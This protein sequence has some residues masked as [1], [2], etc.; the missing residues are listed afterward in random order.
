MTTS[1]IIIADIRKRLKEQEMDITFYYYNY[2]T[3]EAGREGT[4]EEI[5]VKDVITLE[6]K[7][8]FE[9]I[10]KEAVHRNYEDGEGES[11]H[12]DNWIKPNIE[13]EC[14]YGKGDMFEPLTHLVRAGEDNRSEAETERFVVDDNASYISEDHKTEK[15]FSPRYTMDEDNSIIHRK[16]QYLAIMFYSL[17]SEL[18]LEALPM[19]DEFLTL[20][21][22][23]RVIAIN[24]DA[25]DNLVQGLGPKIELFTIPSTKLTPSKLEKYSLH[26]LPKLL[27]VNS[28]GVVNF[29]GKPSKFNF[30]SLE[31]YK[32]D[33]NMD[34][35]AQ[36]DYSKEKSN[37]L[38]F[39]TGILDNY[40][41]IFGNFIEYKIEFIERTCAA[42]LE[43]KSYIIR[44]FIYAV[45]KSQGDAYFISS[46][47]RENT[48]SWCTI[49]ETIKI[50]DTAS[51]SK[52]HKCNQ[53]GTKLDHTQFICLECEHAHFCEKCVQKDVKN[54]KQYHSN[55]FCRAMCHGKHALLCVAPDT[56]TEYL[57]VLLYKSQTV[58]PESFYD[59][60]DIQGEDLQQNKITDF[61]DFCSRAIKRIAWK[62][63]N[64]RSLT[65]CDRCRT[66]N[67]PEDEDVLV[68]HELDHVYL[69]ILDFQDVVLKEIKS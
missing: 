4:R 31:S 43:T 68:E 27:V 55:Y 44:I 24:H 28:K 20:E 51:V 16:G 59:E 13:Y 25:V 38:N 69:R 50:E 22:P 2:W 17:S 52:G 33:I 63:L 36:V 45:R 37:F 42:Y 12:E 14:T 34:L 9:K 39:Y 65:I 49:Y 15:N 47:F 66:E 62:C 5:I 19:L 56:K 3:V 57:D 48:G 30:N 64:C 10:I 11:D 8:K 61:C 35:N 1:E 29:F 32:K 60:D 7:E 46:L 41:Q 21:N 67:D 54:F 58:V 26:S 6:N 23:F 18:S 40:G 53:C